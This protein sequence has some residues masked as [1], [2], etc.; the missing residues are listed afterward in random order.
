MAPTPTGLFDLNTAVGHWP[1]RQVPNQ[2]PDE[3]RRSLEGSGI[4]GAAVANTNGL[5]YKNCHDANLELADGL[6]PHGEFFTGVAT[7]NPLYA[8]WERD[9]LA[10]REVLGLCAVRLVPQ[11]HRYALDGPQAVAMVRSAAALGLP[12]LVPHRVVDV[13]QRHW[14]DTE[15]TIACEEVGALCVAAPEATVIVTE[16]SLPGSALIDAE[17]MWRYPGL[18]LESSRLNLSS[19]PEEVAA[20]R[21][22]FGTGAPFKHMRPAILKLEI[23]D[24]GPS[25]VARIGQ[26]HSRELLR[27]H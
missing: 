14:F 9:L 6:G 15:R 21:I 24:L 2:T 17:G 27:V 20:E 7:L 1:F 13:R 3:L 23:A 12:V 10:C 11:Y 16:A 5:F 25:S 19:F 18:Y 26:C 22:L 8:A 4:S